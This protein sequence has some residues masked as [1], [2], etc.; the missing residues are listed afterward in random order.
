MRIEIRFVAE[1]DKDV[2]T[3]KLLEKLLENVKVEIKIGA[4]W[5][6]A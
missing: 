6:L 2:E 4:S 1:D 3:L 5:P